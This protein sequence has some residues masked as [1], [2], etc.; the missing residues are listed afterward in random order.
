MVHKIMICPQ[1]ENQIESFILKIPSTKAP[2]RQKKLQ[3]FASMGKKSKKVSNLQR[4]MQL[5][6][7]C[8]CKK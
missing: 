1:F 3:T 7:K 4:E 6:Q 5:V 8:M 2:L